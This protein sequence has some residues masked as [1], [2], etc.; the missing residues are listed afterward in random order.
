MKI[1]ITLDPNAKRHG[2]FGNS[3]FKLIRTHGFTSVDYSLTNTE[4]IFYTLPDEE[5]EK[6]ISE[7][8]NAASSAGITI[9][10]THGPWRYPPK[11]GTEEDRAER[12][13]KMKRCLHITKLL[14][15]NYMAIHPIMPYDTNDLVTGKREETWRL[16]IDFMKELAAY[17]EKLG[18]TVCLENLPMLNFSLAKPDMILSLVKE[19]N[20]DYFKICLD[21]G[22]IAVF[23]DLNVGDEVRK[24]GDYIKIL[25]V[26]DN[27][28]DK[29]A[30]LFPRA[31]RIDWYDFS[32]A[33]S[34]IGFS[35]V[36]S[37]ECPPSAELGDEEFLKKSSELYIIAESLVSLA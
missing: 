19:V 35:G 31:G 4:S 32:S 24:L 10:Q 6:A 21:T 17:A 25:H 2:R 30:H 29:D 8:K 36:L 12:M 20:S 27:L 11:D 7:V 37:L 16:N 33:L 13:E 23:P 14:E 9:S 28:G 3:A 22:H 18:V 5:L 26:H 34:E 1:G 15:C